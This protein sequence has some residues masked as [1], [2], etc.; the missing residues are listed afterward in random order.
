MYLVLAPRPDLPYAVGAVSQFS[1][2]SSLDYLAALHHIL[3]DIRGSAHLELHQT[4]CSAF[5]VIPKASSSTSTVTQPHNPKIAWDI[6]ITGY[7]D[8]DW[9]GYLDSHHSTGAYV[10][11]AG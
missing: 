2:A 11:L 9:A 10:F 7:S 3:R 4:R 8:S 1:T 6:E 5:E